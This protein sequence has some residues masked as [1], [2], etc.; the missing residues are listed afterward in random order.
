[1][2]MDNKIKRISS[3]ICDLEEIWVSTESNDASDLI[4]EA[5]G[6]LEAARY[7]LVREE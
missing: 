1:M 5:V 7:V 3:I 2:T 6:N 4:R